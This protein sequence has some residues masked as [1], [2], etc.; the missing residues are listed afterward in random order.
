[1]KKINRNKKGA[2]KLLKDVNV[3]CRDNGIRFN[4]DES[5]RIDVIKE[6]LKGTDY[7]ILQKDLFILCHKKDLTQYGDDT[8]LISTH[9][10]CKKSIGEAGLSHCFSKRIGDNMLLGTYDNSITNAAVLHLMINNELLDN[11]IVAFTGD[12]EEGCN[13]AQQVT[14]FLSEFGMNYRC[15][16]LDVT[17]EGWDENAD[18]TIE[19]NFWKDELGK[20]VISVVENDGSKWLFV[21]EDLKNIPDYI[22]KENINDEEALEDESWTYDENKVECFSLCLPVD[23]DMHK[24]EGVKARISSFYKYMDI[25]KKICKIRAN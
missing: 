25:L 21:P 8:T 2:I 20:K 6:K 13:G 17:Y 4:S 18:F 10:D 23:G 16:V 19:N 7:N 12:E 9:I 22:K 14:E 1:M 24:D 5:E 15:T 11:V 3:L